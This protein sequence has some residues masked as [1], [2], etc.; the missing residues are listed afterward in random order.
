MSKF[1]TEDV[2]ESLC[3]LRVRKSAQLKTVLVLYELEIH[4]KNSKMDYQGLKTKVQRSIDLKDQ[5]TKI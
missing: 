4:E 3:K 2:L 5:I 1:Y